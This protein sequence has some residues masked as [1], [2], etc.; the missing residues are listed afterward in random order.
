[1]KKPNFLLLFSDQH[2]YSY[3]SHLGHYCVRTPSLDKLASEGVSFPN[4]YCQNPLCVPARSALMT[5]RYCK[6]LGIYDNRHC[7]QSNGVTMPK[8]LG[9]AGYKTCVIGKTHFNGEQWQGFQQ[10]PYGDLFGQAHQPDP[11][12]DNADKSSKSGLRNIIGDAGPSGIPMPLTQTE[13]CVAEAAKWLQVHQARDK[14]KP[15]FLSVNFDKPHFPIKSPKE[16][17]DYYMERVKVPTELENYPD[18]EDL[19]PF[20]KYNIQTAGQ[21]TYRFNHEK[22]RIALAAYCGSVEW[23]DNAVGRIVEVLDYLGIKDDTIVIYTT[24]HGEMGYERG[25][26]QKTLFFDASSRVPMIWRCPAK[27]AQGQSP[28]DFAGHIDMLPTLLDLA[29][30]QP[31]PDYDGVPCLIDGISLKNALTGNGP[32]PRD[33]IFCESAARKN[34]V[35]SGCMIRRGKWKY[36]YYLDGFDELYDMEADPKEIKNLAKDP[37][38]ADTVEDLR[39]KVITFWE[40]E[41]QIK[42]WHA[43]PLMNNNKDHHFYS[44][45]FMLGDG[46]VVDAR[47]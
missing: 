16:Y 36:N 34:P 4:S 8:I 2:N 17:F 32:V 14:D 46:I 43:T 6:N 13:I 7:L 5:G 19:V 22:M 21:L 9:A 44:S 41:N 3:M 27:F 1:M 12:R 18:R 39:R 20:V 23:V 47:P 15:F 11:F 38:R 33:E 42:R 30:L 10:R 25:F 28:A 45:Q 31:E 29:E 24:D 26:W 37:V 35:H 40:P